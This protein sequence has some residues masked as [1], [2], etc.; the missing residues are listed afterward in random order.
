[1]WL[2]ISI[3]FVAAA[4]EEVAKKGKIVL[5]ITEDSETQEESSNPL[6]GTEEK[7]P[8][9]INLAEEFLHNHPTTEHFITLVSQYYNTHNAG[10]YEAFHGELLVPPP[11]CA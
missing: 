3:P 6:N 11:N 1:M 7:T 4:K 5:Q 10:T 9:N 2:T 8:G